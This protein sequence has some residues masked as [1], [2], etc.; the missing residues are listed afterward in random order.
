MMIHTAQKNAQLSLSC[1]DVAK[2]KI[3][4]HHQV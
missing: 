3:L 4:M 1:A 2:K